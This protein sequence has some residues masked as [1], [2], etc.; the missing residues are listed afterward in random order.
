MKTGQRKK[1]AL[2]FQVW[3]RSR[4]RNKHNHRH[5]QQLEKNHLIY[6]IPFG[7][8]VLWFRVGRKVNVN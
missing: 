1:S 6:A 5:L 2:E 7:E 8:R 3:P 4:L